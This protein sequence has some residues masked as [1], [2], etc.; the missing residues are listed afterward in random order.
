M[1]YHSGIFYPSDKD[2]LS[3]LAGKR[4]G[5][6]ERCPKAFI[7]P[8]MDLRRCIDLYRKAF[9][10]IPDGK[11]IAALLPLHRPPLENDRP[12]FLF[13]SAGRTEH[14]ITG[15]IEI[16]EAGL[17]HADAY[18]K[19]E[20]SLELLFPL[21][22]S[23]CPSSHLIAIFSSALSA[24]EV[25]KLTETVHSLDDGNTVFIVSSNMTGLADNHEAE[26]DRMIERLLSGEPLLDGY[27][28]GHISACGTPIIEALSRAVPGKWELIGKA[29]NDRKAGHAA[30]F[31]W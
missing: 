14:F 18:E 13:S 23:Y 19:E 22:A 27:R 29:G 7:L 10:M 30:L 17:P 12:S 31:R 1:I 24:G 8:H 5:C 15:D 26:M 20:A 25:R 11:R 16:E 21:I 3:K 6:A 2:E 9:S 28:K 4:D